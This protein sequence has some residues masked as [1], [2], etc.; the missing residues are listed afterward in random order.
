M[1]NPNWHEQGIQ[2]SEAP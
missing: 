1:L 2:N